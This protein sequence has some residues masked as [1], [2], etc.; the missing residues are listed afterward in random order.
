[1]LLEAKAVT[2]LNECFSLYYQ[3]VSKLRPSSKVV[4]DQDINKMA[5]VD[6]EPRVSHQ[7]VQCLEARRGGLD[8]LRIRL[9]HLS[10]ILVERHESGTLLSNFFLFLPSFFLFSFLSSALDKVLKCIF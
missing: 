5:P 9:L 6:G 2:M 7:Q 1:M 4:A 8:A 10:L 3:W